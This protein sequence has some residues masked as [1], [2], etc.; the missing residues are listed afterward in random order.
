MRQKRLRVGDRVRFRAESRMRVNFL[1]APGEVG[2]VV[3]VDPEPAPMTPTYR[4]D[5]RFPRDVVRRWFQY[6]YEVVRR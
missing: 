3:A 1:V 6:D 5:V 4:V 2:E